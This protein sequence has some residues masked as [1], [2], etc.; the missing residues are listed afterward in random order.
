MAI[1][2]PNNNYGDFN[3]TTT[4][5][6]V[7]DD[8][9]R[10]N[11]EII[12]RN[13]MPFASTVEYKGYYKAESTGNHTFNL[14]GSTGVTGY[15]WVSCAPQT[16]DHIKLP[17]SQSI[18][19]V[20]NKSFGV[21]I[22]NKRTQGGYWV[23]EDA[24]TLGSFPGYGYWP[25]ENYGTPNGYRNLYTGQDAPST[26]C[27]FTQIEHQYLVPGDI[28]TFDGNTNFLGRQA[29]PGWNA[30]EDPN[31]ASPC[32]PSQQPKPF[33]RICR[34][35]DPRECDSDANP[36]T[37]G[38]TTQLFLDPSFKA[39][40]VSDESWASYQI[41]ED[42]TTSGGDS[43]FIWPQAVNV[44]TNKNT[45]KTAPERVF[46]R[47][48]FVSSLPTQ[49]FTFV[50]TTKDAL[51]MWYLVGQGESRDFIKFPDNEGGANPCN[52]SDNT[53]S[54]GW[55]PN[56]N[57]AGFSGKVNIP[58]GKFVQF[59][60]SA[61]G[62]PAN[63]TAGWSLVVKDAAGN[64]VWTTRELIQ[65]TGNDLIGIDECGYNSLLEDSGRVSDNRS[66]EM[67]KEDGWLGYRTGAVFNA[68][69]V[70]GDNTERS[71]DTT[72]QYL[73]S[74][75]LTKTRGAASLPGTV[76]LRQG[77]YYFIR[78][79]VS[80]NLNQNA[81]FRFTVTGPAGGASQ[82]VR[83]TGNGDPGS[84]TSVGGNNGGNGIPIS[85]DAL[86]NSVLAPNGQAISNSDT[87]FAFL[88][89]QTGSNR[90]PVVLNLNDL[91]VSD[92]EI[93]REGQAESIDGTENSAT[94]SKL[95]RFNDGPTSNPVDITLT[96]LVRGGQGD[97]TEL[98]QTERDAVL[99]TFDRQIG[100]DK[101][102]PYNTFRSAITSRAVIQWGQGG[103]YPYI[104]HAVSDV[105]QSI[106]TGNDITVPIRSQQ[107]TASRSSDLIFRDNTEGQCIDVD[108]SQLSGGAAQITSECLNT[109][110][111]PNTF[112]RPESQYKKNDSDFAGMDSRYANKVRLQN[113]YGVVAPST[114]SAPGASPYG[115]YDRSRLSANNRD[116][117]RFNPGEVTAVPLFVPD[118][119]VPDE[120]DINATNQGAFDCS[121]KFELSSN[122]FFYN[123]DNSSGEIGVARPYLVWWVSTTPGGPKIGD[124]K[125]TR[126]SYTTTPRMYATMS[127]EQYVA[128][129]AKDPSLRVFDGYLGNTYG[130]R[131]WNLAPLKY[132]DVQ[133][134][135]FEIP[136]AGTTAFVDLLSTKGYTTNE[137]RIIGN[138]T[139]PDCTSLAANRSSGSSNPTM[140]SLPNMNPYIGDDWDGNVPSHVEIARNGGFVW[141]AG[142]GVDPYP[143][144]I[145]PGNE[146]PRLTG[147]AVWFP[148]PLNGKILSY[149]WQ[150][151]NEKICLTADYTWVWSPAGGQQV[152]SSCSPSLTVVRWFS[153]T[154]GGRP[155]LNVNGDR[156]I[157]NIGDAG[158]DPRF[159]IQQLYDVNDARGGSYTIPVIT[160]KYFLNAACIE[161]SLYATLQSEGR[162]PTA[163]E[164]RVFD[165]SACGS[166]S[167][168]AYIVSAPRGNIQDFDTWLQENS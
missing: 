96:R 43:V 101:T 76:Y 160:K 123:P 108:F 51:K 126:P 146:S 168:S 24:N 144:G 83:F 66:T 15:S 45:S 84:D 125:I 97:I 141:G 64:I 6:E 147:N 68:D 1:V 2:P 32:W 99:K 28:R 138:V 155:L 122:T 100:Q 139:S 109:C 162:A 131:W 150:A 79:I 133:N 119:F 121:Y 102:L 157:Y 95:I 118:V 61:V 87:N 80:N 115:D 56:G 3:D 129:L 106:C 21:I 65:S 62:V 82:S 71:F 77:D 145:G 53:S 75:A 140:R 40:G 161:S 41:V 59:T 38:I 63:G 36:K 31:F 39:E 12:D 42:T 90:L 16:S 120:F 167:S 54:T 98:T 8:V 156:N 20:M 132:Q 9:A 152:L 25:K 110:K 164:V 5:P 94:A 7:W 142:P 27:G 112:T 85:I 127:Y 52:T 50:W 70:T 105:I 153:A 137:I 14:T 158:I 55:K 130:A 34:T 10:T 48:G 33:K 149:E 117:V 13:D 113:S 103:N 135:N 124:Y 81:N 116:G 92:F 88:G 107:D 37:A 57:Q 166:N 128:D 26:A 93:G 19:T 151:T 134:L 46:V 74:N 163:S 18:R 47:F 143:A 114:W 60:G 165:P 154:P 69:Y 159:D 136:E 11:N 4:G 86:C 17:E 30:P 148:Q 23:F 111:T 49:E 78:T 73:W 29:G 91:N 22:P 35:T 67:F 58:K 104:Y 72:R 89:G 44:F